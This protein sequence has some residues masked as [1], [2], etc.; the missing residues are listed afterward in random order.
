MVGMVGMVVGGCCKTRRLLPS[1]LRAWGKLEA[2]SP[3]A[4][5]HGPMGPHCGY[6]KCTY[7]LSKPALLFPRR[8]L[9]DRLG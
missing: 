3:K 9:C 7:S 6:A 1:L 8:S 5:W 2:R 4:G